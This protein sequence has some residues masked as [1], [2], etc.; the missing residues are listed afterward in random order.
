MLR[1]TQWRPTAKWT[2][3]SQYVH[4]SRSGETS[5]NKM[6]A[7]LAATVRSVLRQLS[8]DL[9]AP[10]PQGATMS[11][12]RDPNTARIHKRVRRGAL[13]TPVRT[14][15]WRGTLRRP[16]CGVWVGGAS[17]QGGVGCALMDK[18]EY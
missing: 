1:S 4:R 10:V 6:W 15:K 5:R 16:E 18:G 3:G 12:Q 14:A 17:D 2:S 9:E 7:R 13:C 11:R 8:G